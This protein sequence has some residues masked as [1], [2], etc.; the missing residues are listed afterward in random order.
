MLIITREIRD[1]MIS[2]ARQEYPYECCGLLA[3]KDREDVTEIYKLRNKDR[4]AVTYLIEPSDQFRVFK[5]LRQKNINLIAIYHSHTH[6]EAYPSITDVRLAYHPE[7]YYIIISLKNIKNPEIRAFL[8]DEGRI[9]EEDI[10]I[11]SF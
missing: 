3:G 10:G 7:S 1:E 9:T 2:H 11:A 8:I 6:S 5:E 4:S